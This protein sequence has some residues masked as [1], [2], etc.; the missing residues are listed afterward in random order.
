MAIT[1][2]AQR[3]TT[4]T[5]KAC[6]E[7]LNA[8][9]TQGFSF[10]QVSSEKR[11][12][13]VSERS[14]EVEYDAGYTCYLFIT[15]SRPVTREELISALYIYQRDCSCEHD[16]C[17]H[18]TGGA[19]ISRTR[20]LAKLRGGRPRLRRP[21]RPGVYR[22]VRVTGGKSRHWLVPVHYSPNL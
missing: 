5:Y 18:F 14:G 22:P 7:H 12:W 20:S 13:D 15:T 3:R 11:H 10:K 17:G 16:C 2:I 19:V 1:H 21:P 4:S 9:E 8:H 6:A